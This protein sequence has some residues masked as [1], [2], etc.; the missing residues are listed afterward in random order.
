MESRKVVQMDLSEKWKQ[1]HRCKEQ[2]YEHQAG[3]EWDKLCD[4]DWCIYAAAAAT[5]KSLQSCPTLCDPI[6][7]SP[8]GSLRIWN[9]L[10]TLQALCRAHIHY[11]I[12]CLRV[13]FAFSWDQASEDEI[14]E[15]SCFMKLGKHFLWYFDLIDSSNIWKQQMQSHVYLWEIK[16]AKAM[17]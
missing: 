17:K 4:S 7:G 14:S 16:M 6:D 8:P 13:W 10:Q 15:T 3:K 5:A 9:I 2:M 11:L 12:H 1:R